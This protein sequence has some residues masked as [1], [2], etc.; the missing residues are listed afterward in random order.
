M[1]TGVHYSALIPGLVPE[2]EE[3]DAARFGGDTWAEWRKLPYD[4]RVTG[5]AYYRLSRL[6]EMHKEEAVATAVRPKPRLPA[7]TR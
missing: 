1:Q 5:I 2:I 4:E 3:R 7:R 6:I